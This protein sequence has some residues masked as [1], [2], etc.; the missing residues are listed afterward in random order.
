[1]VCQVSRSTIQQRVQAFWEWLLF[2]LQENSWVYLK[3]YLD[4]AFKIKDLEFVSYFLGLKVLQSSQG[5]VLPQRKFTM[6]LLKE[7]DCTDCS[8]V[9]T[10]LDC[11]F[12][13]QHDVGDL[14]SD[15]TRYRKLVGKLNFLTHIRPDITSSIQHLS[16]FIQTPRVPHYQA[17]IHVLIYLKT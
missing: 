5:L 4:I 12:K 15:P 16:Q 14:Y 6:E 9:V 13:L 7:F 1:M 8:R 3:L 2:I 11:N 10:P 17:A